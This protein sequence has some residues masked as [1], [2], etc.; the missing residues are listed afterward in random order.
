M[1]VRHCQFVPT[2]FGD[3]WQLAH[4]EN[5]WGVPLVDGNYSRGLEVHTLFVMAV[6][7]SSHVAICE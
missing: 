6:S 7:H 4:T 5:T 1:I 2:S 3:P